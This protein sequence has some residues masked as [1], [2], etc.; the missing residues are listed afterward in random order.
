MKRRLEVTPQARRDLVAIIDW[1]RQNLGARA[2]LKVARTIQ[3]RLLAMEAGR[4]AGDYLTEGS[5]H[6]RIV[7]R[8]HVIVVH[9]R[10]GLMRIV[11]IVHGSQ[12][13]DAIAEQLESGLD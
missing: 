3:A 10:E 13:L 8:K 5:L 12:D 1:Y 6:K 4:A 7:A 9:E 2:A 11:R